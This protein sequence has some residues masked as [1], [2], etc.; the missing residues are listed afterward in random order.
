MQG[1]CDGC[2]DHE[3][4]FDEARRPLS[5]CPVCGV[6]LE[7]PYLVR[8]ETLAKYRVYNP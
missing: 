3:R 8:S 1:V 2:A 6:E 4:F 7:E 5:V